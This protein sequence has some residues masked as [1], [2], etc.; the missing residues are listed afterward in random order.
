MNKEY[1][2]MNG[3]VT[4]LIDGYPKEVIQPLS[5]M[6]IDNLSYCHF[7]IIDFVN[8][9]VR[10]WF[11]TGSIGYAY[12]IVN[13][14]FCKVTNADNK[15]VIEILMREEQDM[16]NADINLAFVIDINLYSYKVV[17]TNNTNG[18]TTLTPN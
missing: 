13:M 1:A 10:S 3:E 14:G 11:D 4:L 6:E 18:Y 2:L 7:V 17:L 5:M 12:E 15:L 9:E 16:E 8:G